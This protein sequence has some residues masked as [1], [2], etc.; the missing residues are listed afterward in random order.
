[1][2][3]EEFEAVQTEILDASTVFR[4]AEILRNG[5]IVAFPTETV[6]GLGANAFSPSAVEKIFKAKGRP[7]D[8]P[9]IVHIAEIETVGDLAEEFP[10]AA[11]RLAEKFW[12]GPLT[13]ILK[14]KSVV[15]DVVTAGLDTVGIRMPYEPLARELIRL[16]GV[17]VAAPSA[18]ISGRP[19]PT[20]AAHTID[21]MNGRADAVLC[22]GDCRV[23]VESTVLDMSG[24]VPTVLRP[25][26][27]TADEIEA[28]IGTVRSG[29]GLSENEAPKSPGMKYRHYAPRAQVI[30]LDGGTDEAKRTLKAAADKKIGVMAFE[31][32]AAAFEGLCESVFCLG[33]TPEDAA[34]RLFFG[35]RELDKL[36]V[37]VI[38][39]PK[40]PDGDS[41]AAVRNRLY[42][43]AGSK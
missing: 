26:G 2:K 13:I 20:T 25:G 35:L 4:A 19:S 28:V 11:R 9:L 10:E 1:M 42:K 30:I 7:S 21:D 36:G 37:D 12:P 16:A 40:I 38:Y 31:R 6:Y 34:Q 27:I 3:K 17:P 14:R 24:D 29:R 23:G 39:A 41:W 33:S 43:A 15:P 18:N 22:G 8:N 32:D 5:G